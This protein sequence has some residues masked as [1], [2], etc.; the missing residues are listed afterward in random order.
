M[1]RYA[2]MGDPIA[3]SKSPQI[4]SQFASL[5]KQDVAYEKLRVEAHE[6]PARV[7]AFFKGGGSGLN[8]TVRGYCESTGGSG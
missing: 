4:H 7:N 3:Q 2:V 5:T 1:T 6:F 8:V